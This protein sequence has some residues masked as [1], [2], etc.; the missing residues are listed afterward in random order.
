MLVEGKQKR[1]WF[2][3]LCTVAQ[4]QQNCV[5]KVCLKRVRLGLGLNE[6]RGKTVARPT[7][8][9]LVHEFQKICAVRVAWLADA[10]ETLN[11]LA[12]GHSQKL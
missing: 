8:L 3:R 1:E 7:H 6:S 11:K 2:G 4:K 10:A 9:Q 12:H 5:N